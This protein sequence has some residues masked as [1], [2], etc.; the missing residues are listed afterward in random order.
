[1]ILAK[2]PNQFSKLPFDFG[3]KFGEILINFDLNIGSFAKEK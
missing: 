1:V 2:L 3:I